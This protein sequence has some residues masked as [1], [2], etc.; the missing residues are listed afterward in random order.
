MLKIDSVAAN[1][2]FFHLNPTLKEFAKSG[3]PPG[4]ASEI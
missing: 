2:K 4:Y 3:L 1:K